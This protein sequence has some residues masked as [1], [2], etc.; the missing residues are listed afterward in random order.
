[1]PSNRKRIVA[2][3]LQV[4][5]VVIGLAALA[6]L[7]GE[8]H[9]EGRNAHATIFEVYFHDPFLAYV[10]V[11]SVPFFVGL[12]RAFGLFAQ[13]R[14]TGE[15]SAGTVDALRSIRRCA[16]WILGFVPG[17]VLFILVAG[18][19]EDRPV[20]FIAAFLVSSA[21]IATAV[22]AARCARSLRGAL[23]QSEAVQG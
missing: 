13:V 17:G 4:V 16:V 12:F 7:L 18:D 11:G 19:G 21:A 9:V 3:L 14:R 15:F 22:V 23:G 10:Y 8:P 2:L 6:F 5:V 1:M 20:G